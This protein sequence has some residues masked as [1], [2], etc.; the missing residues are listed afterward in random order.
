[1]IKGDWRSSMHAT[2][3][4]TPEAEME[5]P[6]ERV[7]KSHTAVRRTFEDSS[8][9]GKPAVSAGTCTLRRTT[10]GEDCLRQRGLQSS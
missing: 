5:T 4:T 8:C 10:V 7:M 6:K 1:M 2:L 3:P 9:A